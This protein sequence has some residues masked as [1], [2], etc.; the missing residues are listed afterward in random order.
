MPE[1]RIW[2]ELKKKKPFV[3]LV[4]F[5][6][7]PWNGDGVDL[8]VTPQGVKVSVGRCVQRRKN[9]V[10][11]TPSAL[12]S[13]TGDPTYSF[14]FAGVFESYFD[15]LHFLTDK[16]LIQDWYDWLINRPEEDSPDEEE[17]E[18]MLNMDDCSIHWSLRLYSPLLDE[19]LY[20]SDNT[21]DE[22]PPGFEKLLEIVNSW[23]DLI[24]LPVIA[25]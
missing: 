21:K 1:M 20:L 7:Q 12:Y 5:S 16:A 19:T 8:S 15:F 6:W 4:A 22:F 18:W 13:A 10:K 17:D 23:L 14:G 25:E 24:G 2:R 3:T 11:L 9:G